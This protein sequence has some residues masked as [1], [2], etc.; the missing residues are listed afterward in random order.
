MDKP[1]VQQVFFQHIKS[2]LAG[3]LSLVD[4]VA[5]LLN[6]SNDSAYRRIR[7]EKPLTFEEIS[8]LCSKY[9]ISMDQLFHL[10]NDSYLFSG[11]L[12]DNSNFGIEKYLEH[13]LAQANY[14]N[15]FEKREFYWQG[16]DMFIFHCFGFHE[17]TVF[18]IFFWMKTILQYPFEGREIILL[19]SL[20]ENIYKITNKM[21]EA[22]NK[23]PSVEIWNDDSMNATL[24]QIDYYRQ[25]KILPSEEYALGLYNEFLAMLNHLEKQA[26]AGVKFPYGGKPNASS[27][28]FRLYYNEF[29]LGDNCILVVLNDTKTVYINHTV[30]NI[31]TTRDP[32]FSEYTY[33][34]FLNIMRKSTLIS[35]TSEKVRTNFFNLLREKV[36]SRIRT[37]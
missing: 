6:I 28:S 8:V 25:S 12:S 31:I 4:E 20:R 33:Q 11:P 29:I 10:K 17:L 22:Y 24:R 1:D 7:G 27:Q 37:F 16:K 9:H 30:L 19:E 35:N 2:N 13:L 15:T 3:H 23:F 36:E 26:E 18:K 5:E 21:I 32:V 14:F 34:H